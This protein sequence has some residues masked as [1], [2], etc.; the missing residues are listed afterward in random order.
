MEKMSL[1][2]DRT[3]DRA[4]KQ[5]EALFFIDTEADYQRARKSL[6]DLVD[7]IGNDEHHPRAGLMD[8][9]ATLVH[10]WEEEHH[11]IPVAAPRKVLAFLMEQHGLKQQDLKEVGTQGIVSEV[12]S[13]KRELN[14]RQIRKLAARFGV[15]PA[16]FVG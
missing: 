11:R 15:S 2:L 4:W 1:V 8:T 7:E 3:T 5:L 14:V 16:L 9:L 13:G 12:L 10:A 6:D